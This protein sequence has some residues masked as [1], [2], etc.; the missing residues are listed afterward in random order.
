[1]TEKQTKKVTIE[2][3]KTN[4]EFYKNAFNFFGI[5][6]VILT[7]IFIIAQKVSTTNGES[8]K[9]WNWPY[10]FNSVFYLWN[11]ENYIINKNFFFLGLLM[12]TL[13][14]L[15]LLSIL[16]TICWFIDRS[17]KYPKMSEDDKNP[18][19]WERFR[20]IAGHL[21][22]P[23]AVFVLFICFI[24]LQFKPTSESWQV[25]ITLFVLMSSIGVAFQIGTPI[26]WGIG[27]TIAIVSVFALMPQSY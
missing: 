3:E 21:S 9:P 10:S 20:I 2:V 16:T 14:T 13:I 1:M 8:F 17:K 15:C 5:I 4:Q 11:Q 27:L 18:I 7:I 19:G 12:Y 26:S 23:C 6:A 22:L 25:I 24:Y